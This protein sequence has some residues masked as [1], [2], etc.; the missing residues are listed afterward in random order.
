[1]VGLILLALV[2][3]ATGYQQANM[4]GQT[5]YDKGVKDGRAVQLRQDAD[6]MEKVKKCQ[7]M[8]EE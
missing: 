4:D 6:I 8:W 7:L 1:M 5:L 3:V 2:G